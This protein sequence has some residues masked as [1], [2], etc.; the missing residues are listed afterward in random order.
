MRFFTSIAIFLFLYM[1]HIIVKCQQL[2]GKKIVEIIKVLEVND[3]IFDQTEAVL[4]NEV[5]EQ[6]GQVLGVR[7]WEVIVT[8]TDY[9]FAIRTAILYNF[10]NLLIE[11][12]EGV[13]RFGCCDAHIDLF[14][15]ILIPKLNLN[16]QREI[17][18]VLFTRNLRSMPELIDSESHDG[19]RIGTITIESLRAY[20]FHLWDNPEELSSSYPIYKEYFHS[21]LLICVSS[22]Y[23]ILIKCFDLIFGENSHLDLDSDNI[24]ILR[25]LSFLNITG[26]SE[27]EEI[28]E[29]LISVYKWYFTNSSVNLDE[30][31]KNTIGWN[32]RFE[33][34][35]AAFQDVF[36]DDMVIAIYK[37]IAVALEVL[38][39]S[40]SGD[41]CPTN[42]FFKD[43]IYFGFDEYE[44]SMNQELGQGLIVKLLSSVVETYFQYHFVI[45]LIIQMLEISPNWFQTAVLLTVPILFEDDGSLKGES[46]CVLAHF[47]DYLSAVTPEM[48]SSRTFQRILAFGAFMGIYG[49]IDFQERIFAFFDIKKE[50]RVLLKDPKTNLSNIRIFMGIF[51]AETDF[52]LIAKLKSN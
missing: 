45:E 5:I 40:G 29:Q 17:V 15:L 36:K 49:D 12:L 22:N 1:T 3:Q 51:R 18:N 44:P 21:P 4:L 16:A 28:I 23:T 50:F 13:G 47:P 9:Y 26:L 2:D 46:L 37:Y 30:R 39:E 34:I 38:F 52:K 8:E 14:V 19:D 32:I 10:Q 48:I 24:A 35:K 6:K 41:N 31:F 7:L 11:L 25:K 33:P 42:Q 43:V 27:N 20:I